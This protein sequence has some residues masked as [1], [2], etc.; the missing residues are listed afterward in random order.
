M[1]KIDFTRTITQF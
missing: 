1:M